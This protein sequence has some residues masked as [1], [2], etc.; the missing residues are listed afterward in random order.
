MARPALMSRYNWTFHGLLSRKLE[1]VLFYVRIV[2]P[3]SLLVVTNCDNRIQN[4]AL[5]DICPE[6]DKLF[7]LSIGLY[8]SHKKFSFLRM[9]GTIFYWQK[10]KHLKQWF[11][12][13]FSFGWNK[14]SRETVR[15][16]VGNAYDA[17]IEM[18]NNHFPSLA[19][20]CLRGLFLNVIMMK[21][22]Q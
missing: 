10:H 18:C 12:D 9:S 1:M 20:R 8:S 15:F 22:L 16:T 14:C 21:R 2:S 3:K 4:T 13:L 6:H 17:F 7:D 19:A 5:Q 11:S